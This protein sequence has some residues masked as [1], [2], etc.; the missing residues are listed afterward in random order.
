M[1]SSNPSSIVTTSLVASAIC[2]A[3]LTVRAADAVSQEVETGQNLYDRFGC[4]QCHGH[5]GQ[6]GSAGPAL[7]PSPLPYEGFEVFVRTPVAKMPPYTTD[8]LSD[9]QLKQIRSYLASLEKGPPASEI[10]L[11]DL[12]IQ[13]PSD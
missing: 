13:S 7:A 5:Y 4:Y 3:S 11:L 1:Q 12:S 8:V 10:P 6:G 2:L 9:E